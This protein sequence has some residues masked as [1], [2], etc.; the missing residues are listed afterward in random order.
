[1]S[2][3]PFKPYCNEDC[4]N[5][6]DADKSEKIDRVVEAL[7]PIVANIVEV[8]TPAI[9]EAVT[10]ISNM[11]RAVIEC[12]PNRRVVHLALHHHKK[13]IRKKNTKRIILWLRE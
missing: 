5:C 2:D 11:W 13:K 7:Q 1:M 3:C 10:A 6:T 9:Q 8:L 12:Y 4:A